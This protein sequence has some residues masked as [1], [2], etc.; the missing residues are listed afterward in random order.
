MILDD[1]MNN[2]SGAAARMGLDLD[3]SAISVREY[4]ADQV[5]ALVLAFGEPGYERAVAAAGVNVAL[6]AAG[7]AVSS[8][9]ALDREFVGLVVGSLGMTV[10]AV[11]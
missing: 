6:R 9:D 8:A 5:E 10:R 3:G 4:A 2:L 1:F 11:V 7:A